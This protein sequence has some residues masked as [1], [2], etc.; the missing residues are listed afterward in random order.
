MK[1]LTLNQKA[2]NTIKR[3]LEKAK[4]SDSTIIGAAQYISA[5]IDIE[6]QTTET[7][8]I[9]KE[10]EQLSNEMNKAIESWKPRIDDF[11][12][13]I[14]DYHYSSKMSYLNDRFNLVIELLNEL[15][16]NNKVTF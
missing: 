5:I 14:E 2:I 6:Q 10:W 1:T 13:K 11:C 8:D 4:E 15:N 7:N 12:N 16:D 9:Q 3:A